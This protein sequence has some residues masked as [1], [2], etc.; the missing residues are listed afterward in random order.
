MTHKKVNN[1]DPGTATK[2]GGNDLDKWSDWASGV[3]TDDYDINSD[4][5]FRTGKRKLRN[6]ANTFNYIEATS[7]IAADR[8]VTEPLLTGNDTRVYQAHTQTL[9][10]KTMSGATNTFSAIPMSALAATHLVSSYLIYKESTT[11]YAINNTDNTV[12]SNSNFRILMSAITDAIPT[13]GSLHLFFKNGTYDIDNASTQRGWIIGEITNGATKYVHCEGESRDGVIF[14]N[15]YAPVVESPTYVMILCHTHSLWENITF[16]GNNLGVNG[17]VDLLAF[18]ASPV[19]Q[20]VRGCKFTKQTAFAIYTGTTNRGFWFHHNYFVAK[21]GTSYEFVACQ[22][23]EFGFVHHNY[24]DQTTNGTNGSALTFGTALNLDVSDNIIQR[25][26]DAT[27]FGISLEAWGNYENCNIHDNQVTNGTIVIGPGGPWTSDYTFRRITV[28]NNILRGEGIR[29]V[30][31]PTGGF[32]NSIKD[33]RISG[34]NIFES[35]NYGL[36]IEKIADGLTIQNNK[37]RDTN[38][39]N[40]AGTNFDCLFMIE[41]NNFLVTDNDMR[42][43]DTGAVRNPHGI[44]IFNCTNGRVYGNHV[45]NLT[46]HSSYV[47]WGNNT[48]VKMPADFSISNRRRGG[49]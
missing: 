47:D 29:A 1:A 7:A 43:L 26:Q 48:N 19:Y 12:T 49:S 6:P 5:T 3:D 15:A 45:I 31:R 9:T 16:D 38:F 17:S 36:Y 33:I 11:Y 2:F 22:V 39:A 34:N 32:T 20:E 37:V 24:F 23:I 42:M 46:A 40:T 28:E 14:R 18:F 4:I 21:T 44:S 25:V 10:N 35:R 13:N 41:C 27:G 8:T 30:G